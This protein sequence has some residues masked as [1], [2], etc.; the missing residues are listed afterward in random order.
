MG[1]FCCVLSFSRFIPSAK[2]LAAALV[3]SQTAN[4]H[5]IVDFQQRGHIEMVERRTVWGNKGV[6]GERRKLEE[7]RGEEGEGRSGRIILIK[8]SPRSQCFYFSA[9]V[10][11]T[12]MQN[13]DTYSYQWASCGVSVAPFGKRHHSFTPLRP[14]I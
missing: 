1:N 9:T 5:A 6:H 7:D 3:T 11:Q 8:S 10:H 14:K 13:T 12:S 2:V 4:F